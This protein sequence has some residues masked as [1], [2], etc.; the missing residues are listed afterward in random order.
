MSNGTLYS[1]EDAS[2]T[3]RNGLNFSLYQDLNQI[4]VSDIGNG[5]ADSIEECLEKCSLLYLNTCGAAAFDASAKKCFYKDTNVTVAGA[6]SHGSWTLGVANRTQL[7]QLPPTCNNSG[8]T[9]TT[10]NGLNFSVYCYQDMAGFDLCPDDAPQCRA[11]SRGMPRVL[12]NEASALHRR[13]M[14][15]LSRNW[16]S[17]LLSQEYYCSKFRQMLLQ[18]APSDCLSR[19]NTNILANNNIFTL[20]CDE[21]RSGN[22][23]TVLHAESIESCADSCGR[24]SGEN[25]KCLGAVFDTKMQGGHENCYLKSAIGGRL[26]DQGGFIFASRQDSVPSNISN[27]TNNTTSNT[28]S[29]TTNVLSGTST[30]TADPN[31][32]LGKNTSSTTTVIAPIV[33]AVFGVAITLAL[34]CWWWRLRRRRQEHE[35]ISITKNVS[36]DLISQQEQKRLASRLQREAFSK[37]ELSVEGQKYELD[38]APMQFELNGESRQHELHENPRE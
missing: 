17:K 13:G 34:V 29:P 37:P 24:I 33:G 22:N 32:V 19:S 3:T 18:A 38:N 7:Q 4:N 12:L 11:Q 10:R 27:A 8:K 5:G 6:I 23:I 16:I 2:Y 36:G 31:S 25:P 15:L 30:S 1:N 35:D 20:A 28:S 9:Q 26:P 14:G 21:D